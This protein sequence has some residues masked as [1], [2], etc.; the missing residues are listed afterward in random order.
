MRAFLPALACD[1]SV[2][3][4]AL[5][6]N[7]LLGWEEQRM[8]DAPR[9]PFAPGSVSLRLYP[10]NELP[11]DE[12]VAV[13][14]AQA[15]LAVESGFDGVMTSEHHGG[16]GGY[17]PNPLQMAGWLLEAMP[18]GW[19]APCPLLLP[20][21]P[22]A[23]VAEEIA[24]LAARFPDRVGLG[25]ASGSL[26]A[27]FEI[28]DTDKDNLTARFAV[29]L[30]SVTAALSGRNSGLLAGDR[31]IAR[32]A[33][34][35]IPVVSAA[36]SKTACRRAASCGAGLLFAGTTDS[37]NCR[38]M[39]E[40]YREAG[41]AG[42][43]VLVRR[44]SIGAGFKDRHERQ[45]ALYRGY[46]TEAAQASWSSDQ[47]TEGDPASIAARL[48][49]DLAETGAESLNLRAHVPGVTPE[50]MEAQIKGLRLVLESLRGLKR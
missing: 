40:A 13:M 21:R 15:R 19:A 10:H 8:P 7:T 9:L 20:L 31:A 18:E 39:V 27:D 5:A 23:L 28:M 30:A 36:M 32:C 6:N 37:A 11:A 29:G 34:H 35:P 43:I 45:V 50:E 48:I 1:D 44:V 24:W 42:P 12:I 26:E 46:T 17:M 49:S 16:F 25:V 33:E 41:G 47:L 3:D 38:A 2:P 22:W 4:A 14:R